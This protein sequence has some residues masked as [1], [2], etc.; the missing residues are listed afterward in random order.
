[1]HPI[2]V[3]ASCRAPRASWNTLSFT[4][5]TCDKRIKT[6]SWW[7]SRC[8]V[9]WW[10]TCN[11]TWAHRWS[12]SPICGRLKRLTSSWVHHWPKSWRRSQTWTAKSVSWPRGNQIQHPNSTWQNSSEKENSTGKWTK[13]WSNTYASCRTRTRESGARHPLPT[14]TS[15]PVRASS[16]QRRRNSSS[17][18][19]P[20]AILRYAVTLA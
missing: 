19:R 12:S 6:S 18:S 2:V 8:R 4:A 9:T 1:M 3:R 15:S 14:T 17:N 7:C 13:H 5:T 16:R 11:K 20:S 10:C